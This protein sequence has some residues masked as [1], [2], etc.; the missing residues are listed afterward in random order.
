[1]QYS[2]AK[3]ALNRMGEI[4]FHDQCRDV[5]AGKTSEKDL[6]SLIKVVEEHVQ[7]QMKSFQQITE[8][9]VSLSSEK[10][11]TNI[12]EKILS[13]SRDLTSAQAGTLYL[14]DPDKQVLTFEI[15]QNDTMNISLRSDSDKMDGFPPVP[16]EKDGKPNTHNVSSFVALSGKKVN[17]PDVYTAEGFDFSGTRAYDQ[18]SGYRSKS[19]LVIPMKN[20]ERQ[21]IGVLQIINATDPKTGEITSFSGEQEE[22]VGGL[23][24]QAAIA[25]T[26]NQLIH[27]LKNLLN[28]F[29]KSIAI[30]IDSKSRHT[31]RHVD[32]VVDLV[33]LIAHEINMAQ[34]G[35]FK[36]VVFSPEETEEMRIASWLHDV[37]KINTPEGVLDKQ[38]R[39]E[40]VWDKEELLKARFSLI[41]MCLENQCLRKT[42]PSSKQS[43]DDSSIAG[44]KELQKSLKQDLEF[45]LECNRTGQFINDEDLTRLGD[46][47][48]RKYTLDGEEYPYLTSKELESLSI[49]K[50][51]L[52]Q[53]ERQAI[54]NHAVFTKK[55]LEPLPFPRSMSRV[56]EFAAM[57]HEKLDGSGYPEGLS[58]EAIPLQARILAVADV[59]EALTARDRPYK[60]PMSLEKAL[61]IM[62]FMKK[63]RHLDPDLVDFFIQNKI[64]EKYSVKYLNESG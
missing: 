9:G 35:P 39:L 11:I 49:R 63:D 23:A 25:L 57:H 59:F 50:G 43:G 58:G 5:W 19:M 34:E 7:D 36:E 60:K 8:V 2:K 4:L 48:S 41:S 10:D 21:I 64:Y 55:I 1:M 44:L 16:L 45:L 33:L 12:L 6:R 42:S 27:D 37:G 32:R 52:S 46:I 61:Q 20:H 30:A 53:D 26:K 47:A 31:G 29:I 22:I 18:K 51:N 17:I 62:G 54:E 14:L 3:K 40:C 13:S 38:T 24:S 56:P 15:V 28:S